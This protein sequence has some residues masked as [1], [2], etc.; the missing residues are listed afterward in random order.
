MRIKIKNLGRKKM[1][2]KLIRGSLSHKGSHCFL[3]YYDVGGRVIFLWF[4]VT[5]RVTI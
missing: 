4:V 3:V 5:G 2:E 1:N